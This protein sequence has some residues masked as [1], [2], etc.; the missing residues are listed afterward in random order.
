MAQSISTYRREKK[1]DHDLT[2]RNNKAVRNRLSRIKLV[3]VVFDNLNLYHEHAPLPSPSCELSTKKTNCRDVTFCFAY[4][5]LITVLTWLA[6]KRYSLAYSVSVIDTMY[7]YCLKNLVVGRIDR[8]KTRLIARRVYD[9]I[10]PPDQRSQKSDNVRLFSRN[11]LYELNNAVTRSLSKHRD[12]YTYPTHSTDRMFLYVFFLMT[13]SGKRLSDIATLTVL[14]LK[15]LVRC[16][17]CA[18]R[19]PKTRQLSRVELLADET[20]NVSEMKNIVGMFVRWHESHALDI[21]FD[22]AS[23]RRGLD[24]ALNTLYV[25]TRHTDMPRIRPKGLSFHALRRAYAGYKFLKGTPLVDIQRALE[26]T[27]LAQTNYYVNIGLYGMIPA[28]NCVYHS[29]ENDHTQ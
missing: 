17:V 24:R 26:H 28:Q 8:R 18:I 20:W 19:V 4:D 12:C 22:V 6:R 1:F 16:G 23:H 15:E 14:Q 27:N 7:G 11:T 21:P 29:E 3:H 9:S 5:D 13:A 10:T 2:I 25:R